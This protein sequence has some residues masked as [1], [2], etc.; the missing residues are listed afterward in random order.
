VADV[1]CVDE[2]ERIRYH[3]SYIMAGFMEGRA[4]KSCIPVG[5]F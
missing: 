2:R 3:A 5:V 4:T 1:C